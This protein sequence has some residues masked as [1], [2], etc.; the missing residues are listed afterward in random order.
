[1]RDLQE[2]SFWLALVIINAVIVSQWINH[3]ILMSSEVGGF[4]AG[5][6]LSIFLASL[7][8]LLIRRVISWLDRWRCGGRLQATKALKGARVA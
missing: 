2:Y 5:L 3:L 6:C 8:F 4:G 1:M 7:M